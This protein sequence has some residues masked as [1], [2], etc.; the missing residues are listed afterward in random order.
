MPP[1][2]YSQSIREAAATGAELPQHSLA[3][4]QRLEEDFRQR[5]ST[6][7]TTKESRSRLE[8]IYPDTPPK[9]AIDLSLAPEQRY[10]E[11]C[12]AFKEEIPDLVPLFDEV[13]GGMMLTT[14][15]PLKWLHRLCMLLLRGLHDSDETKELKG[16]SKATGVPMYLL[17]CFNVLLDLF[18]GCSSGGA[19]VRDEETN[20]TKMLH[21]RT[22]DWGMPSLR[23]VVVQLDFKTEPNGPIVA[24]SLTYAGYVGVLTG[25]RQGVSLS[26]NFRP[27]RNNKGEVWAD[28]KYYRHL[29]MVLLGRRRSISSELRRFLLPDRHANFRISHSKT[30]WRTQSYQDIINQVGWQNKSK[31]PMASTACYLCFSDGSETTIFEKDYITSTMRQ[32][33]DFINITNNDKGAES[34][35]TTDT[36][37]Q[38]GATEEKSEYIDAMGAILREAQDRRMCAEKNYKNERDARARTERNMSEREG[39]GRLMDREDIV[40]L[41]QKYP[42]TNEETH[43]ACVMDPKK[44]EVVWCR[45]WV[46]PISTKWIKSHSSD[47][48]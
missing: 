14:K 18:M 44:G 27:T 22:L 45:R 39:L 33:D 6:D 46:K 7:L 35:A 4:P 47:E 2:T 38:D 26:L 9:F 17:V 12:A 30:I 21:F 5:Q 28:T 16:I 34:H 15:V 20:G 37:V 36:G 31:R 43:F 41:V 19:P 40:R 24:S 23:R 10:L 42:T 13:L 3:D 1:A 32:S 48:W 29:I 25:V 8:Q 11:V